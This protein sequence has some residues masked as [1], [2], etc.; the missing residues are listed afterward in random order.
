MERLGFGRRSG[1]RPRGRH[2]LPP[3]VPVPGLN[4]G[5]REAKSAVAI[6]R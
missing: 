2:Q 4:S 1:H 6:R 3:G 5:G